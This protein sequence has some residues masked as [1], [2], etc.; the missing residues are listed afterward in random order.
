MSHLKYSGIQNKYREFGSV[1]FTRALIVR[2]NKEE[3]LKIN[4][5]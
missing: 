3:V 2:L 1:A 4:L 5:R